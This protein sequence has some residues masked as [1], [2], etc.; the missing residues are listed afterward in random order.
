M[1]TVVMDVQV[2]L[3]RQPL[4]T[5]GSPWGVFPFLLFRQIVLASSADDKHCSLG[6]CGLGKATIDEYFLLDEAGSRRGERLSDIH[7]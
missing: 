4:R 5:R 7:I 3:A 1:L 6:H 2:H